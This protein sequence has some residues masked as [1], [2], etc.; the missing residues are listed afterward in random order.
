MVV[1][2]I[3]DNMA[4]RHQK[5]FESISWLINAPKAEKVAGLGFL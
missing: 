1:D 3:L 2:F 4:V 5:A